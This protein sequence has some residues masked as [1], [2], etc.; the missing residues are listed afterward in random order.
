MRN[1]SFSKIIPAFQS[2]RLLLFVSTAAL[3]CLSLSVGWHFTIGL[4]ILWFC[5]YIHTLRSAKEQASPE[6]SI[7]DSTRSCLAA[8]IL[9]VLFF[10]FFY[11]LSTGKPLEILEGFGFPQRLV[12]PMVLILGVLGIL[13]GY[14]AMYVYARYF[15]PLYY[16]IRDV[17]KK[18]RKQYM[19][20]AL[21]YLIALLAILRANFYFTDD[22]GRNVEGYSLTGDFSRYAASYLATVLHGGGWLTDISPL[23]Q[24]LAALIMALA[25]VITLYAISDSREFRIMD[26]VCLVPFGLSPY[27]LECFAY[28]YDATYMAFSVLAAVYP[29]LYRRENTKKYVLAV[30]LS[31]MLVCTTY[32]V[33]AG[34]FPLCVAFLCFLSWNKGENLKDTFSFLFKSA[35]AYAFGVLFFRFVLMDALSDGNYVGS[36]VSLRCFPANIYGYFTRIVEDF[37]LIWLLLFTLVAVGFLVAACAATKRKKLP[38]LLM[39]L[40]TLLVM[41]CLSNGLYSFFR[42]PLTSARSM[43]GFG[44]LLALL[45]WYIATNSKLLLSRASVCLLAWLMFAFCFTYGNAL[46]SQQEYANFRNEQ[47]ITDLSKLELVKDRSPKLLAVTGEIGFAESVDNMLHIYPIMPDLV[48]VLLCD[49]DWYWGAYRLLHY[50]DLD[51][52]IQAKSGLVKTQDDLTLLV[53]SYY[54]RISGNED[55]ILIELK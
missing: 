52:L 55:Y 51:H 53:D 33:S 39:S 3:S 11:T 8:F 36:S 43:Y 46:H 28:K 12:T 45:G 9:V 2:N 14:P 15:I 38:A 31:T 35:A 16:P 21:I 19:V 25:A 54:H 37:N 5:L 18:M 32:Q 48:P 24:I 17:L 7:P 29:L 50:Y 27:F 47:I 49:T 10:S 34:V 30:A 41:F 42:E 1:T 26:M 13:V 22:L 44:I 23:P 40:F 6:P 20:L 4:A